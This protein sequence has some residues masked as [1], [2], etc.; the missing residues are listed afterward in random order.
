[1]RTKFV[2]RYFCDHC[3]KGLSRKPAMERHEESCIRN[4]QRYCG[5]CNDQPTDALPT[6]ELIKHLEAGGL[7]QLRKAADGCPA[8]ILAALVQYR[9]ANPDEGWID[10]DYRKERGEWEA[11]KAEPPLEF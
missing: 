2:K 11:R 8:C 7:E 5:L 10:F 4:P 3:S 1:M 9:E 6:I